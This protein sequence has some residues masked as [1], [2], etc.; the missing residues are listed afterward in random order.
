MSLSNICKIT[1][2][3]ITPYLNES[4][5]VIQRCYE[6]VAAQ[7]YQARHYFVAD[8]N[9]AAILKELDV[10]HIVLPG[11]HNDFGNT[12][13]GLGALSAI[14]NGFDA[15][16]FLDADNWYLPNHIEDA[17]KLRFDNSSIDVSASYRHII[18]PD[19]AEVPPDSEDVSRSHIDTSCMGFFESSFSI[20]PLWA[21]MTPELSVIGDRVVF[22]AIKARQMMIGW[23]EK[24]SMCYSSRYKHHYERVGL[25]PPEDAYQLD[26]SGLRGFN[27]NKFLDWNG[28]TFQLGARVD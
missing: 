28:Y 27:P 9:Q 2:A 7:S 4:A 24:A 22:Q 19:G 26:L 3:V 5:E 20:L 11:P 25:Q 12:P 15:I 13:R 18:L 16:F 21:T 6:S 10:E 1:P 23:T 8:G 14:N 17:I